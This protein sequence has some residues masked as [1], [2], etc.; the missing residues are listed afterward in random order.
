MPAQVYSIGPNKIADPGTS[1]GPGFAM[2]RQEWIAI[3]AYVTD[4]LALPTT[5]E[6]FRN[7]LGPGAPQDLS[8]FKRLIDAYQAIS[9]HV[10]GW[11]QSVFP[12]TVAL[13]S[14][15]YQYGSAKAPVYYPPI[16]VEAQ[17]L[18]QNPDDEG[19]KA[20]LKAIL[21]NLSKEAQGKADKAADVARQIAQFAAD[22]EADKITMTGQDGQGGLV[23][24]YVDEYGR[25]SA[26]VAELISQIGEQRQALKDAN[27]EYDHDVV[28][29]ATTP[30]YV[31]MGAPGLIAAAVVAGVYGKRATEALDRS[32]AAEAK[33]ATLQDKLAADANLLVTIHSAEV[34]LH[35]IVQSVSTA[36]PVIQ[37]IQG[38]WGGIAADLVSISRLIDDDI[39]NV[40]PIIMGLGVDEAVKSWHNVALNA[41]TYRTNAYVREEP[42][43][44]SM[45]AWKVATQFASS[46]T[47]AA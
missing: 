27:D 29:A 31:W 16:L 6:T 33:I 5:D 13:A 42:G 21:D 43:A 30:T 25:T 40:P 12:A 9:V 26:E 46:R 1:G 11:G 2:S 10:T 8:D 32:R 35:N 17:K 47:V 44:L 20:A 3:Q 38:V 39:R 14:D 4:A 15:I 41:D 23:K 22:T 37:K 34:A 7:S 28:V 24:D 18:E 45:H 19:A 36:L